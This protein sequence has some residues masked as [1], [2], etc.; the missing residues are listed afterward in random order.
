MNKLLWLL[1]GTTLAVAVFAIINAPDPAPADGLNRAAGELGGWGLKQRATGTGGQLLGK[2]KEAAGNLTGDSE[3]RDKGVFD[4]AAGAVKDAA[5]QA[6]QALG[7]TIH[8][9]N[10]A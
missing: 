1:G 7:S 2:V 8:D 6:A 3:T 10:K 9:L 5:G 4:Q